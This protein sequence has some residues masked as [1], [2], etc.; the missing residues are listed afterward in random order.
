MK[1]TLTPTLAPAR[2]EP[3]ALT[4]VLQLLVLVAGIVAHSVNMFGYPL[5]LGD[6]GMVM[7][8]SW[9]VLRMGFLTPYTYWYDN[10]PA[11]WILV[12]AWTALTG[13]FHTFGGSVDGGR[14][15]MLVVHGISLLLVFRIA[16]HLSESAW[17]AAAAGLL[18]TLT[19]L[20]VIYGRMVL[21]DNIMVLWLLLSAL[22]LLRYEGKLWTLMGAALCYALAVLTKEIA[23][24]FL[25]AFALGIY[26]LLD[27]QHARFARTG[28]LYVALATISLYGL[29]A[30]LKDEL[31]N[32]ELSSPLADSR[33]AVTLA[34]ALAWQLTR[35]GGAPWDPASDVQGWLTGRWL[36][37]DPWLL[38]LGAMMI[39][40]SV[41]R[42]PMPR[43][44][45]GLMGALSILALS[46]GGP[47]L[48]QSIVVALPWLAIAA[49]LLVSDIAQS[50]RRFL[51]PVLAAGIVSLTAV[52]L[53]QQREIFTLDLTS[54]QRQAVG[55]IQ[56][57]VP[58]ASHMII[59]DDIWVDLQEPRRGAP[60][61]LN[62]HPHW[63][64]SYDPAI[65]INFFEDAWERVDYIVLTPGMERIFAEDPA[66]LSARAFANSVEVA[67][68]GTG[69]ALVTV[70]K[71]SY[72]GASSVSAMA[73]TWAGFQQRFIQGDQVRL[74]D[75][76]VQ[77]RHQASAMLMAVWMD[78]RA[79][80][81]RLWAWAK[82]NMLDSRGLLL[83]ELPAETGGG[84]LEA[85]TDAATALLLAANRWG[86]EAYA[87]DGAALVKAI[88]GTYVVSVQGV[89]Y[90][91]AGDWAIAA[92]QVVFAPAS[93]APASYHLFANAD[94]AGNWWYTLDSTYALVDRIVRDPL[95]GERSVGLP[96]AYVGISRETGD[97]IA[98][99]RGAP[100]VGNTFN[101][102][103]AELY[104]RLALDARLHD[105][106]RADALLTNSSFL[107]EEW[108]RRQAL[109]S[110]YARGGTPQSQDESLALYSAVLPK[111]AQESQAAADQIYAA[112]LMPRYS[113]TD[114]WA[115]W[116]A[117]SNIDEFRLA[118]LGNALYG[119]SLNDDWSNLRPQKAPMLDPRD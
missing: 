76:P 55:W 14:V 116:G 104:W 57:H 22:L 100:G 2:A 46:Y 45:V 80:F 34:G 39:L 1:T 108:R 19:P 78:D 107:S 62:A 61:F 43:R 64:A 109:S 16:L 97:L 112:E 31:V 3:L 5:F 59:D 41:A 111:I 98:N 26:T 85:N 15:L 74:A 21:L 113:Q 75:A 77:S 86:D 56:Q 117:G 10:P 91:A 84:S 54:A 4:R 51:A 71:V 90:L 17:A 65:W 20:S 18:Y 81:D 89:P 119:G 35:S 30:A 79:T 82:A 40:L 58:P 67:R 48:E 114:A 68:F 47:V 99:P 11:G 50:G 33:G 6:E 24:I 102:Y 27:R 66:A 106:G 25:P 49:G 95:G 28:W 92:D 12:A 70:R 38:G 63:K 93:F 96:P 73:T 94:P 118:W 8:N 88:R 44:V 36:Q 87:A 83:G 72:P 52:S 105:D 115:L 7:Q 103:A 37:L 110:A 32:L 42:G 53:Y 69:D 13:G 23:A 29:F 101:V 9:A 60:A